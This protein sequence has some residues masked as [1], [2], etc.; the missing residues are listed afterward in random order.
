MKEKQRLCTW[1]GR[2]GI[3]CR[4]KSHK[5]FK[6]GSKAGGKQKKAKEFLIN[7]CKWSSEQFDEVD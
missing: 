1:G 4:Q 3:C 5:Q 2:S 6:Q 7:E